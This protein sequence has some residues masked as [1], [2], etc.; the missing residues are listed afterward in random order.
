MVKAADEIARFP[1]DILRILTGP[2]TGVYEVTT[3]VNDTTLIVQQFGASYFASTG[4][5]G[6]D[7]DEASAA[8]DQEFTVQRFNGP[9]IAYGTG[10]VTDGSSS[11]IATDGNFLT[12]NVAVGDV[13]VV[14]I[15]GVSTEHM[16]LDVVRATVGTQDSVELVLDEEFLADDDVEYYVYREALLQNPIFSTLAAVLDG[17]A[18]I[19]I[20]GGHV[21]AC[22]RRR[23]DP[24]RRGRG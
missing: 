19:S 6:P 7:P 16:V 24:E 18:T 15:S 9:L 21:P 22:K 17:T 1:G 8:V 4:V 5:E 11:L 3:V 20:T 10:A 14:V 2:N 13:I 12:N 23:R